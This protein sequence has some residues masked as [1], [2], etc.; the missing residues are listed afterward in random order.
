MKRLVRIFEAAAIASSVVLFTGPASAA[1]NGTVKMPAT[2]NASVPRSVLPPGNPSRG[3]GLYEAKCGGCHSLDANRIGPMHRGVVGRKSASVPG[4]H[5]SAALKKLN[6]VWTPEN[7]DRWL[8][9]P[10]AFAPGTLMGFRLNSAQDRADV[11][12][13][14]KLQT[15]KH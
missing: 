10:T 6:V 11:I 1:Q 2:V 8:K 7:L 13:Y 3:E 4:Y 15:A 12:A 9:N 14:L 5:Y